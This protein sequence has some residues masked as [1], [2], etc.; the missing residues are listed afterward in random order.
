[1]DLLAI[2]ILLVLCAAVPARGED[3]ADRFAACRACHTENA[4][5]LPPKVPLLGGQPSYY[6]VF[7]LYLFRER[8]RTNDV[9]NE[10]AKSI[11]DD[12]LR[13]FGDAIS[14]LPAPK[15]LPVAIDAARFAQ[16]NHVICRP[17]ND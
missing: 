2:A 12:E 10:V 5:L 11:T 7:Q 8:L 3:F 4:E 1:M 16:G 14:S 15:P 6:V 17:P 13:L 9:M